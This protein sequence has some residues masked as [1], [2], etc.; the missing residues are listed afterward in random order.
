[1]ILKDHWYD[2]LSSLEHKGDIYN[3]DQT[4]KTRSS[5]IDFQ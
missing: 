2:W 5:K 1:M 4:A 3:N